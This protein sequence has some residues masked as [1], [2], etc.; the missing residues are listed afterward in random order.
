[1]IGEIVLHDSVQLWTPDLSLVVF[2]GG[3]DVAENHP[4]QLQ[5]NHAV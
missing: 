2:R 4:I 5:R 3:I 1:M